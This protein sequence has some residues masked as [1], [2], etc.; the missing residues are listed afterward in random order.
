M[1]S[2][3]SAHEARLGTGLVGALMNR[4]L[5]LGAGQVLA[6][7][8]ALT[9]LVWVHRRHRMTRDERLLFCAGVLIS[10]VLTP[11]MWSHYLVLLAAC[12]LVFDT[13]LRWLLALVLASWALSPPHNIPY[14]HQVEL[15]ALSGLLLLLAVLSPPARAL[16][17]RAAMMLRSAADRSLDRAAGGARPRSGHRFAASR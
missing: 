14:P 4:G 8:V 15:G 9:F 3:L 13:R 16:R 2:Q 10:L 1:L 6:G 11:V 5:S 17:R 7:A 12:L